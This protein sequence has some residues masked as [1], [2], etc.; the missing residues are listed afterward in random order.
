MVKG[1]LLYLGENTTAVNQSLT[2]DIQDQILSFKPQHGIDNLY[3]VI[4]T[5]RL[6]RNFILITV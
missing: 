2:T 4:V 6:E 5:K 1:D 3:T